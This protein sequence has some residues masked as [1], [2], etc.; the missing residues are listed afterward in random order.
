MITVDNAPP[1]P[2]ISA[3]L[4]TLT[5]KVGDAITF[6]GSATDPEDGTLPASA[7][8]LVAS[9]APLPVRPVTCIRP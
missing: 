3:P 6:S 2:T 1:V 8:V 9:D 4:P 5:W 7:L